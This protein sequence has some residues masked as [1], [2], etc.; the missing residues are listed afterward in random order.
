MNIK[1]SKSFLI[2]EPNKTIQSEATRLHEISRQQV[3]KLTLQFFFIYIL[4]IDSDCPELLSGETTFRFN[5]MLKFPI[6]TIWRNH[7]HLTSK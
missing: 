6:S 2:H 3:Q 7:S 4:D 5:F 1:I